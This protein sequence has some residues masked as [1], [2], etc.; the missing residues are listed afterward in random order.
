M[1]SEVSNVHCNCLRQ[2]KESSLEQYCDSSW[3]LDTMCLITA[4][5]AQLL[6]SSGCGQFS[7]DLV[8]HTYG[9][10]CI[11]PCCFRYECT[12]LKKPAPTTGQWSD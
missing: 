6:Q 3:Q 12:H 1:F 11:V 2:T 4:M 8:Y 7:T 10:K 9:F 5:Y